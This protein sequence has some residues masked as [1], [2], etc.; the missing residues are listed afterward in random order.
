MVRGMNHF[1]ARVLAFAV[2]GFCVGAAVNSSAQS[3]GFN[4]DEAKVGAY[5]LPDP[6]TLASGA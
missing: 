3:T 1:L 2:A 6:L 4:Y 5:T